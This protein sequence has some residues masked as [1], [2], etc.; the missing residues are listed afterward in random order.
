MAVVAITVGVLLMPSVRAKLGF[1]S[2]G[3]KTYA[4]G[5]RVDVPPAL[6]QSSAATLLLFARNTCSACQKAKVA[7]ARVAAR[8]RERSTNVLVVANV[9]HR[10]D[11]I[12]Y[13]RDLGLDESHLVEVDFNDLRLKVVPTLVL[14]DREG[15]VHYT[16]EG[17]ISPTGE[18]D[19]LRAAISLT[20]SR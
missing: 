14:V 10:A 19:L 8:L 9:N 6:Y 13:V 16:S 18:E 2:A 15:R 20:A 17:V 11:E 7:F 5:E 4:V 1:P 3:A 12:P